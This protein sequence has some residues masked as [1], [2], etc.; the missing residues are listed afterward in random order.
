MFLPR[1]PFVDRGARA[2]LDYAIMQVYRKIWHLSFI[3]AP[4]AYYYGLST[5]AAILLSLVAVAFFLA[6]DLIRFN[7]KR[8]NEI[9]YRVLPWLLKDQERKS[10]NASIYFALSCLICATFFERR[11][12]ALAIA[13]LCVGD[14][15]AA[16]VGTRYGT[17]RILN[18]SFQGSLA[19]FVVCYGV[20]RLLFDPT[21]SFWAALTATFFELISSRL[22]DNLSIPIFT[23]LM[24][25]S[26]LESPELT[27]PME[28]LLV[29][30][31]VYL[32]FV[33]VTSLVGIG[34]K[35]YII[36]SYTGHYSAPLGPKA[37]FCPSVSMIK[38]LFGLEGEDATNL[39]SF[40]EQGYE[41]D[42]EVVFV[43]QDRS[44]PIL[45]TVDRLKIAFPERRIRTVFSRKDRRITDKMN[46]LIQGARHA[47]GDV[48]VFSDQPA[49]VGPDYL[50]TVLG[51]L[52]E[53]RVG[54]VTSVAGY[55]G[56]RNIPAALNSHLVNLLGQS[57]YFALAFFDRLDSAN[58]CTLGIRRETYEEV[59]GFDA[60]SDQLSDVHALA[61]AVHRRGYRIH[62]LKQMI[63][64]FLPFLGFTEW[65]K[66]THRMA[67]VYRTYAR[68]LYPL[69]LFQLGFV[70][71][72][73]YS[74][75]FPESPVG[76]ALAFT[77]LLA[78]TVSHLRMNYLY[79]RDRSTY[80]FIWLLPVLL[81][82][83]PIL[84]A[85]SYF[86]RVVDWRGERY[87]VDQQGVVTRLKGQAPGRSP[88][89]TSR[90]VS[91]GEATEQFQHSRYPM[92]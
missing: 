26:L 63:P 6:L 74:W 66:R 18:K 12:A 49:R 16:I 52:S 34:L 79:V 15:V 80:L 85:S 14:P 60:I 91:G 84:W 62:L 21:V 38:P 87:F 68:H 10:L 65:L 19:C 39:A 23:G 44:D 53:P 70:H 27:G 9:A 86:G 71:A 57:L 61:E 20:S 24:V 40:C 55:C 4:V 64:V 73:L 72:L 8:G 28:Y 29:F 69:F 48:L 51:P 3:W 78:E 59:G 83:A 75:V 41:G 90:V 5:K 54:I 88:E 11:V 13:L 58:G 31:K 36:H 81:V 42:W 45:R 47:R 2:L 82:V 25:T 92:M 33:I 46:N 32:T 67:V 56:A 77:S 37:G 76:P 30:F 7:W 43:V 50:E 17:I 1:P 22:N 89:P 35:H